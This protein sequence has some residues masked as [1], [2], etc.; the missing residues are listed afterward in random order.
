MKKIYKKFFKKNTK[1]SDILFEKYKNKKRFIEENVAFK[2]C[3]LRV[4]DVVSFAYQIKEIFSNE[5]YKFKSDKESPLIYD[6]GANIGTSVLYFKQLFPNSKIKA[7]EADEKIAAVLKENI[8]HLKDVELLQNAVWINDEMLT[9]NSEGAD[10]GSL[11][12]SFDNKQQVKALRLKNLLENDEEI[13]FL[14]MDIEG[15]ESEVIKD[16][17]DSLGNVKNVFIEYHSF[18]NR[19]QDL[20]EIL[21][22]LRINGFR[23]FMETIN[24]PANPFIQINNADP[25]DLQ[26]NI[27]GIKSSK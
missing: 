15:A 25:M 5:I 13:D 7:F 6:C 8:G 12:G 19:E 1:E 10:G 3:V 27:F 17:A 4:P 2:G 21:R 11:V 24:K 9:F 16:C 23:Y 20:D 14:K 26:V 18:K 22:I